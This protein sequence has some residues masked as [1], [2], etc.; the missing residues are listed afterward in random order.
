MPT[1]PSTL[2]EDRHSVYTLLLTKTKPY[3]VLSMSS[4]AHH[5]CIMNARREYR[6]ARSVGEWRVARCALR[7][8]ILNR[9]PAALHSLTTQAAPLLFSALVT[10]L[11]PRAH[12]SSAHFPRPLPHSDG[13]I[14]R[15]HCLLSVHIPARPRPCSAARA[16]PPPPTPT[17][18]PLAPAAERIHPHTPRPGSFSQRSRPSTRH[19]SPRRPTRAVLRRLSR[20]DI[21]AHLHRHPCDVS[22]SPASASPRAQR[23]PPPTHANIHKFA[24]RARAHRAPRVTWR[25]GAGEAVEERRRV[26]AGEGRRQ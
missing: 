19:A 12:P 21:F 6:A 15:S 26:G 16:F 13:V 9:P 8:G 10:L 2:D 25:A 7:S 17:A 3:I 1:F 5:E 22:I 4:I 23:P 18:T 20:A 14:R 11:L 24:R